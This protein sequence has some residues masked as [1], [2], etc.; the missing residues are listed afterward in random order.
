MSSENVVGEGKEEVK[1][2]QK[3]IDSA[4][5]EQWAEID[6]IRQE[7]ID[8]QTV[9]IKLE[10][11]RDAIVDIWKTM[12]KEAPIVVQ[13][14][15]PFA[16]A[17]FYHMVKARHVANKCENNVFGDRR[18]TNIAKEAVDSLQNSLSFS[19]L[20]KLPDD[21]FEKLQ[22]R[23][24]TRIKSHVQNYFQQNPFQQIKS[25]EHLITPE[26]MAL[27]FSEI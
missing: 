11:A 3:K 20:S 6:R 23:L 19:V 1:E 12:G 9:P 22:G 13:V 2:E 4:T 27:P 18:I 7:W 24:F 8:G 16:A 5:P 15:G 14:P 17:E 25:L 21:F 10:N 26:I